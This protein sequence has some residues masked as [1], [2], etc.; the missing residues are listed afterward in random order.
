[1]VPKTLLKDLPVRL[2]ASSVSVRTS[3][4]TDI[5]NALEQND[6]LEEGG[7][8]NEM[9]AKGLAR[10]LP[11]VLPRYFDKSRRAAQELMETVMT[12][13]PEEC[14]KPLITALWEIFG[15]WGSIHPTASLAKVAVAGLQWCA[16]VAVKG[17][18]KG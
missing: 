10:V 2:Q 13:Y 16:I 11:M 12:K 9:A 6:N 8:P 4:L 15:P 14:F 3:L 7:V 1:M 18:D 17:H 5:R